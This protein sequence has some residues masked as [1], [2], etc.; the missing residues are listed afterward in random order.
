M[1]QS[2]QKGF[3]LIELLISITIISILATLGMIAYQNVTKR[4]RDG[5]RLT[6]LKTIQGAL[7]RYNA[8]NHYF[9][10]TLSALTT[11][12]VELKEI[13]LDPSTNTAYTYNPSPTGCNNTTANCLDYCLIASL[14]LPSTD[15]GCA[16]TTPQYGVTTP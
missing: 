7:Q 10:V 5:K 6:D 1:S 14:E 4:A 3:T 16:S 15:R 2:R 9:P 13:P 8:D 12:K 11:G